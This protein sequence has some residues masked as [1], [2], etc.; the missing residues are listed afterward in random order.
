MTACKAAASLL[1]SSHARHLRTVCR[2]ML[3]RRLEA[4]K[5]MVH[6]GDEPQSA[7][8]PASME[9]RDAPASAGGRESV[10]ELP[11]D[12]TWHL[13]PPFLVV[14]HQAVDIGLVGWNDVRWKH[15][16]RTIPP[17]HAV[18]KHVW[19]QAFDPE[20]RRYYYYNQAIGATEWDEPETGSVPDAT[21]AFYVAAGAAPPPTPPAAGGMPR[22][23]RAADGEGSPRRVAEDAG[24]SEYDGGAAIIAVEAA[25]G[26]FCPRAKGELERQVERYW[27]ARYSL[28][29]RWAHGVAFDERSLYSVTPEVLAQHQAR[30]LRGAV[31]LDAFCGCG[32]N[33]LQFALAASQVR[34]GAAR[35]P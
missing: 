23:V 32:G 11:V 22:V 10:E 9:G 14:T 13:Q 26:R 33:A 25:C 16:E 27:I 19:R 4:V 12:H 35:W 21:V 29:S 5:D 7:S 17:R 15:Q 1:S 6:E 20:A 28:S 24:S 34:G 31:V 30:T 3:A 8:S 18:S 2:M